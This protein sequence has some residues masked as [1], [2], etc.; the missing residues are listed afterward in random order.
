MCFDH[1][2]LEDK[3]DNLTPST[4]THKQNLLILGCCQRKSFNSGLLPA[5]SRYNGP[6]FQVLRKFLK[7]QPQNFN[8]FSIYILSAEFGLIPQ[9][10]L[11][12]YYDRR[13]TPSRAMELQSNTLEK[14]GEIANSRPYKEV[15][16]CIGQSYYRAIQ[17]YKK[18]LPANLNVQVAS[19]SLGRKL[20]ELH[21]WLYGKPPQLPQSSQKKIDLG[22]NLTIKGIEVVLTTQQVLDIAYQSL[23]KNNKEF[24]N[25]QS[26][27]VVVGNKRVAP[28]WLVNQITGLPVSNFT[29]KE[30]LRLLVQL[31]IEIHRV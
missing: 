13:M 14:L 27:Y 8:F 11:I 25:F 24:A 29:T 21:E 17:G 12:P 28:K 26:W 30:A 19:G 9:D 23:E 16:I 4:L 18:I 5:I 6:T 2:C 15:F 3:F 1:T 7:Q 20:G 31:G 22:K 10:F